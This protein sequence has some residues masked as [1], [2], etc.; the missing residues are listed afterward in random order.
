MSYS[1]LSAT[2]IRVTQLPD[3]ALRHIQEGGREATGSSFHQAN[4]SYYSIDEGTGKRV[5]HARDVTTAVAGHRNGFKPRKPDWNHLE[6]QAEA[7]TVIEDLRHPQIDQVLAAASTTRPGRSR[8]SG[9]P[10]GARASPARFEHSRRLAHLV[11]RGGHDD[12]RPNIGPCRIISPPTFREGGAPATPPT[13][14][15]GTP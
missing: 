5:F 12:P 6:K 4:R 10:D 2:F 7:T 8:F 11:S 9:K 3:G 14:T 15:R 13:M 1:V